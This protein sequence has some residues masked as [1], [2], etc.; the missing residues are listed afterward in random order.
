MR[1]A[2][3][4]YADKH[5]HKSDP[6][7]EPGSGTGPAHAPGNAQVQQPKV[8][9]GTFLAGLVVLLG[10]GI[11]VGAL[12]VGPTHGTLYLRSL[13]EQVFAAARNMVL[14]NQA[15]RFSELL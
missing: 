7:A 2:A 8:G 1:N 9:L 3:R 10:I 6:H 14:D 15:S 5:S 4:D 11:G 12:V 13:P